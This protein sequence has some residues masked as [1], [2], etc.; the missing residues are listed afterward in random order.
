[1]SSYDI[2]FCTDKNCKKTDCRRHNNKAKKFLDSGVP[3]LWFSK[4]E[5]KDCK[6][7]WKE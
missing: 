2:T 7:Y 5:E 1:M 3:F 4:M 6:Y